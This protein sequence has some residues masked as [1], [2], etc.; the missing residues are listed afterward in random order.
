MTSNGPPD[1]A[2]PRAVVAGH[3]EFAAGM[4][5][6]VQ[7]ISGKGGAFRG[8]SNFG[9]DA[10]GLLAAMEAAITA[11]AAHVVFTD[12]PAGSC[13]FAARRLARSRPGLT[14][15]TGANLSMLLEYALRGDG[16]AGG[17]ERAAERGRAAIAVTLAPEGGRAD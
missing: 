5:S 16:G 11:H 10:D 9:L 7:L 2:A 6:A 8:L 12:L 15:V 4:I 13:T 3:G 1:P 17:A 14:V